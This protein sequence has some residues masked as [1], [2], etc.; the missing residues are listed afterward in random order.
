MPTDPFKE[1][2]D[3][4]FAKVNAKP[5]IDVASPLLIEVRNYATQAFQRCHVSAGRD[6]STKDTSEHRAPLMLYQ[7]I[8]EM[9][10]GLES[11]ISNSC[12]GPAVPILRS[13]LEAL[14][15][16]DYMLQRD[17]E[18]RSLSWLCL[19]IHKRIESY[20]LLDPTT[21]RGKQLK[22]TL[23]NEGDSSAA[24]FS[25]SKNVQR[26]KGLL[27]GALSA[28]EDEYQRQKKSRKRTPNWYSLFDG[29][30]DL[31]RLADKVSR[32]GFYDLLYRQWSSVMH[33]TDASRF[34]SQTSDGAAAFHQIRNPENLKDYAWLAVTFVVI[35][36]T[37]MIQKFGTGEDLSNLKLWYDTEV[38]SRH[39][40]L[41]NVL[42][43][44]IE[45]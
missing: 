35:S 34:L 37:I 33:A 41:A 18:R 11:L 4:D 8:I 39:E 22:K 7:H 16:L 25:L 1:L 10:D 38:K 29:P 20:E 31:R 15:S 23:E 36:T 45:D 6:S 21:D 43:N 40:H 26:L 32:A 42:S 13:I 28:I 3:P 12:S 19:H 2:L 17:Y 30:T 9:A 5:I 24:G 44:S 27:A 14:L